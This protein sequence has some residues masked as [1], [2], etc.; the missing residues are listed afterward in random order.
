[1]LE[2][3]LEGGTGGADH[4]NGVFD[5]GPEEGAVGVVWDG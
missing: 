1:M 3:G 2:E 5:T 4:G